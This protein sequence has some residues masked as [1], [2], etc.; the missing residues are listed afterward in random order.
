MCFRPILRSS[1]HP[2]TNHRARDKSA[3]IKRECVLLH[4]KVLLMFMSEVNST[5]EA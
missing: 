4:E 5:F 2:Q 1:G 3:E